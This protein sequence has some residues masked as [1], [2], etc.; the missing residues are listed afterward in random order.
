MSISAPTDARTVPIRRKRRCAAC[1]ARP[2]TAG[3]SGRSNLGSGSREDRNG[4]HE[5]WRSPH[6]RAPTCHMQRRYEQVGGRQCRGP[7]GAS[8]N[9]RGARGS[10]VCALRVLRGSFSAGCSAR[11]RPIRT[12]RQP[13]VSRTS[14]SRSSDVYGSRL[15]VINNDFQFS[16]V[17]F[18]P[19]APGELGPRTAPG[20][21]A[22]RNPTA[23]TGGNG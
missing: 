18:T 4:R 17:D 16:H 9:P 11:G 5:R 15:S 23:E 7:T 20:K 21:V 1:S 14:V 19:L 10:T 3:S 22:C 12:T 8:R 2:G 13:L 6:C